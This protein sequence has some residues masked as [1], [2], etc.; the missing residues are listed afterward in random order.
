MMPLVKRITLLS[1]TAMVLMAVTSAC[2]TDATEIDISA[3]HG[4]NVLTSIF[5]PSESITVS[6][7]GSVPY[8][9]SE[10]TSA[11]GNAAISLWVNGSLADVKEIVDGQTTAEFPEQSLAD[12]D[13]VTIVAAMANGDEMSATTK[14]LPQIAIDAADTTTTR[15]KQSLRFSVAMTDPDST[16]DFYLMEV[17]RISYKDGEATDSVMKCSYE[18]NAF[19]DLSSSTSSSDAT[20]LFVDER[21][22]KSPLGRTTLRLSVPWWRIMTPINEWSADSVVAEVRL[23]HLTEDYYNFLSTS[24]M[25]NAYAILPIFGSATVSTNVVG[26]YGIV[27]CTVYDKK[28]FRVAQAR[29]SKDEYIPY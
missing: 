2:E 1:L 12:N 27:A 18:S 13:S 16:Y 20:G 4:A 8:S 29:E 19:Y 3:E 14:V 5:S 15:D 22:S 9:S 11:V 25:L 26:G 7:T 23:Y 6:L 28:R 10:T 24:A 17:R 21:L